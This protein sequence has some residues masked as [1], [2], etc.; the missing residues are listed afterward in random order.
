[1]YKII[2]L[3]VIILMFSCSPKKENIEAKKK[4]VN[5]HDINQY[6]PPVKSLDIKLSELKSS[7]TK[8]IGKVLNSSYN[9]LA[10]KLKAHKSKT[11]SKLEY[12]RAVKVKIPEYEPVIPK[13]NEGAS[14][15]K[16]PPVLKNFLSISENI[17]IEHD[18][19]HNFSVKLDNS[20][21]YKKDIRW[22]NKI[23]YIND[24]SDR[25][26]TR[27][28]ID[29]E[30]IKTLNEPSLLLLEVLKMISYK[31]T[32]TY[33]EDKT[34]NS[35]NVLAF[36]FKP[37][38][39]PYKE[40]VKINKKSKIETISGTLYID[41]ETYAPIF[42][43]LTIKWR[44][45]SKVKNKKTNKPEF[46]N[47]KFVIKRDTTSIGDSSIDIKTPE[48]DKLLNVKIP[49]SEANAEEK[50]LNFKKGH[51]AIERLRSE[52]KKREKLLGITKKKK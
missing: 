30:H 48:Q 19:G 32:A 18:N 3:V 29:N 38:D 16:L 28:S 11:F 14:D 9:Y 27:R 2:P 24:D 45:E 50:I 43:D 12:S 33:K 36:E 5:N 47:A 23:L 52:K 31:I 26:T 17:Y 10:Q 37:M 13:E 6:A 35:R 42:I 20:M 40:G 22:I 51:S 34:Y 8:A 15:R 7:D 49:P 21:G 4:L 39:K 25:F 41:K 1:M 46:I 44:F